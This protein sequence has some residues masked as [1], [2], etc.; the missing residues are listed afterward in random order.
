MTG[1]TQT[2]R[3][4][5]REGLALG[6]KVF[7]PAFVLNVSFS[8]LHRILLDVAGWQVIALYALNFAIA[9]LTVLPRAIRRAARSEF[10]RFRLVVRRSGLQRESG[11]LTYG[12]SL[13]LSMLAAFG[14]AGIGVL[15]FQWM[16]LS[17]RNAHWS[18]ELL[19][20]LAIFFVATAG[21]GV[22]LLRNPYSGFSLRAIRENSGGQAS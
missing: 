7:W 12:E 10:K 15:P 14:T 19:V 21:T 20:W 11:D 5:I 9:T 18:I 1:M 22:L 3:F 2:D 16:L 13:K 17:P 4:S 6:E 8:L